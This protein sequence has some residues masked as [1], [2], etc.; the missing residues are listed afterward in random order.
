MEDHLDVP[1]VDTISKRTGTRVKTSLASGAEID[2]AL[3]RMYPGHPVVALPSRAPGASPGQAVFDTSDFARPTDVEGGLRDPGENMAMFETKDFGAAAAEIRAA[4]RP[5]ADQNMPMFE[6]KDFGAAAAQIRKEQPPTNPME[7]FETKDFASA[8]SQIRAEQAKEQRTSVRE[9][10][11]G[12]FSEAA[13]QVASE[14]QTPEQRARMRYFSTSDF[15]AEA[16]KV[17]KEDPEKK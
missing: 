6:T 5:R 15:S 17:R 8:A 7:M 14:D 3:A 9:L 2:A 10:D 11:S 1:A 4:A 12:D 13:K 16:K